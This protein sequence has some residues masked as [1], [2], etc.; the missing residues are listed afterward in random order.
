MVVAHA[1]DAISGLASATCNGIKMPLAE[2][3]RIQCIVVLE[4]GMN[5]IVVEVS[6][7]AS[8]SGSAG[9]RALLRGPSS[10]LRVVPEAAGVLIGSSR[11]FQVLDEFGLDVPE[12]VWLVDNPAL[13]EI[14]PDGHVLTAKAPGSVVLKATAGGMTATAFVTIFPG[15]RLPPN[16]IRWKVDSLTTS[17]R[18][19]RNRW[20]RPNAD[21][22]ATHQ[23]PGG[24]MRV[25]ESINMVSGRLNWRMR[26]A[27]SSWR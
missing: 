4:P 14:S 12:V 15:D 8:N 18:S 13:A 7:H 17:N 16:S 3:G 24:V 25:V 6:D 20:S 2:S 19:I 22:S 23:I 11:T 5:D 27:V 21:G 10:R 1:S 9:L 26:P